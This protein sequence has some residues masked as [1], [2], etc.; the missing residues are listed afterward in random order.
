VTPEEFAEE[1]LIQKEIVVCVGCG[2]VGK[3]TVAAALALEAARRGRRVLVLT[4][5]PARRLADAL[6]VEDLGNRPQLLPRESL[7][8][9]GVPE[10]GSLSAVMLDMKHT[11]DDLVERFTDTAEARERVFGNPI[12]QHATETLAGSVEY[13]A[14]EKVF[15]LYES[16]DFDLILLDTPP[17]QHALDFLEAPQRLIEFLDSRLVQMLIHP[18]FVAGRFGFRLFHRGTQRVL[19]VLERLSGIG[20]LEDI[21]EFLLAF[22]G[23]AEGFRER[24]RRVRSLLLGPSSAF[25]LVAAPGNESVRQSSEFLDRLESYGVPLTG[26]LVNRARLWPSGE[27]PTEGEQPADADLQTLAAA[28]RASEGESFPSQTAARA[29]VDAATGYAEM[30]RSDARST[31]PLRAR[32]ERQDRFWGCIPEFEEDV[33]DLAGLARVADQIVG[34]NRESNGDQQR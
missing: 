6:G 33:H 18:A 7:R 10:N 28:L 34:R 31:Q 20:F 2:G 15:E 1:T 5:D 21:S 11:F 25:L 3:T 13:S 8:A 32:T 14:M 27:L 24:A 19:Q 22:E 4:I 16:G 23:M 29:A 30:V 17:S 12:Y 9:L 26:V